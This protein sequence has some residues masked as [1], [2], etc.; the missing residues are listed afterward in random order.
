MAPRTL[1]LL[2]FSPTGNCRKTA[3]QIASGMGM[4][5]QEYDRTKPK[6]RQ[7]GMRFTGRDLVVIVLPAYGNRLPRIVEGIFA[8]ITADRSPAVFVVSYGNNDY[9]DAL[10]ELKNVATKKGFVGI[11]AA[12]IPGEHSFSPKVGNARP[13]DKDA[14][15]AHI[16]GTRVIQTLREK[17]ITQMN[18]KLN[19]PGTFPYKYPPLKLQKQP[20]ANE[21]C[22]NCNTCV[23]SC[24]TG[25]VNPRDPSKVDG[26]R[27]LSCC[28]CIRICPNKA[29]YVTD[30]QIKQITEFL[31]TFCATRKE[32]EFFI[33]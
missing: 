30:D 23:E 20:T 14:L 22:R 32:A 24:P 25:A 31:E 13:D 29:R 26:S 11:A 33:K 17:N 27:C 6:S 2:Y 1:N 4:P 28:H 10:L 7:Q 8:G 15:N 3:R 21:H 12:A 9:G 18:A 5:A 19:V 16:F